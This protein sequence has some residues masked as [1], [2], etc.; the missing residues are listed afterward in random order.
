MTD[1]GPLSMRLFGLST[2]IEEPPSGLDPPTRRSQ[3]GQRPL[4]R[5][6]QCCV[7]RHH[8]EYLPR[9]LALR[10]LLF[11]TRGF[12]YLE[13]YPNACGNRSNCASLVD[14]FR[15]VRLVFVFT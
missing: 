15:R 13:T 11:P 4:Q 8:R 12:C 14:T 10:K 9:P 5:F 7:Y 6:A 3:L 1:P 2:P